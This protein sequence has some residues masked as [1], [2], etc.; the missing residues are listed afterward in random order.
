VPVFFACLC[1]VGQDGDVMDDEEEEEEIIGGLLIQVC[2][3]RAA[4]FLCSIVC[5][6]LASSHGRKRRLWPFAVGTQ[7]RP[8]TTA[9]GP[10]GRGNERAEIEGRVD[11]VLQWR[12]RH[13]VGWL[14]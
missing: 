10:G 14:P 1:A 5:T 7:N 13:P 9:Q 3:N 6:L 4:G 2:R 8:R 12:T 11:R